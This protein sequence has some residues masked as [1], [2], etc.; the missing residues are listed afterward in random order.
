M[1]LMLLAIGLIVTGCAKR[2]AAVVDGDPFITP[3]ELQSQVATVTDGQIPAIDNSDEVVLVERVPDG[4]QVRQT[5]FVDRDDQRL[6]GVEVEN[7]ATSPPDK[8]EWWKSQAAIDA[9]AKE[10]FE[11]APTTSAQ[12]RV[13]TVSMS[14]GMGQ[15]SKP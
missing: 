13:G 2:S 11:I 10:G 6:S 15:I 12:G 7:P 8:A 5:I 14:Y 1:R 3:Q 4:T 9:T